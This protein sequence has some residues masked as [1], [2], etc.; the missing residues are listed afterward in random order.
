M[1]LPDKFWF[2]HKSDSSEI[3]F[4]RKMGNDYFVSNS[5]KVTFLS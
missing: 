3:F 4:A 1:K 2:Y 5:N